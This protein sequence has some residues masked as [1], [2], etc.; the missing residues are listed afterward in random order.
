MSNSIDFLLVISKI[1]SPIY[2][3]SP[4][5]PARGALLLTCFHQQSVERGVPYRVVRPYAH[6]LYD[7][8]KESPG[9][10]WRRVSASQCKSLNS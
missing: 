3:R 7:R 10:V 2:R 8:G 4:H 5:H 6:H 9:S 1:Q